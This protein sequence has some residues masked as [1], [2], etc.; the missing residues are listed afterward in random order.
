LKPEEINRIKRK[1]MAQGFPSSGDDLKGMIEDFNH[2]LDQSPI[3]TLRRVKKTGAPDRMIEALC[4]PATD[5]LTIPEIVAEVERI[6]MDEL[7]YRH[8]EAHALSQRDYEVWLDFVTL[9]DPGSFYVTGRIAVD[10]RKIQGQIKTVSFWYRLAGSGWSEAG[11]LDGV[12]K[13]ILTASHLS[14]ALRELTEAV[15]ALLRGGEEG[16]C[17][18]QEEP[19]EHRWIFRRRGDHLT[20]DILCFDDTFSTEAD[21]RG[22]PVFSSECSLLRFAGQLRDQLA[23]LLDEHGAKGYQRNWGTP[24]PHDEYRRLEELIAK[25]WPENER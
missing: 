8:H 25:G 14:D 4:E 23:K 6:W 22:K 7:R 3:L 13:A 18:W 17:A 5:A 19:G 16:R 2:A 24:F 9:S 12:D 21:E 11:I 20:I 1:I 10:V 15:I